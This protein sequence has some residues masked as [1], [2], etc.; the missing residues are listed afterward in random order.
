MAQFQ[1][2]QYEEICGIIVQIPKKCNGQNS[3][4]PYRICIIFLPEQ[5]MR[6]NGYEMLCFV[7][8]L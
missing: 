6:Q 3:K 8:N 1:I 2:L 4:P 7:G 5:K